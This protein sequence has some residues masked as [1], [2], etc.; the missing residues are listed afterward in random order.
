MRRLVRGNNAR[1]WLRMLYNYKWNLTSKVSALPTVIRQKR[2][3]AKN[4]TRKE[5]TINSRGKDLRS[6]RREEAIWLPYLKC[7]KPIVSGFPEAGTD[8]KGP[9]E[10]ISR[11]QGWYG[12]PGK[13]EAKPRPQEFT[14][15][16][17]SRQKDVPRQEMMGSQRETTRKADEIGKHSLEVS[18]VFTFVF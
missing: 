18:L 4:S 17:H 14:V 10:L 8:A 2:K 5:Q 11:W 16:Q 1:R 7:N 13:N 9:R 3:D 6:Y 12:W 15:H